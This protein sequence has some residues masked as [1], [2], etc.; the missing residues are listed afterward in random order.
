MTAGRLHRRVLGALVLALIAMAAVWSAVHP[1]SAVSQSDCA[2]L[3]Q[4]AGF[5]AFS[6]EDFNASPPGGENITGRIAAAHN[7]AIEGPGSAGVFVSPAPGDP[8]PTVIAGHDL[9]LGLSGA[10]GNLSG[11]ARYGNTITGAPNFIVSGGQQEASPGFSFD[12]EFTSLRSLSASLAD[13]D[14]TPGAT[15]SLNPGSHA[16][17]LRGTDTATN[18]FTVSAAQLTQAAGITI[19]LTKAG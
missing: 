12:D 4:A 2:S 11:G 8:S 15:V 1:A 6:H 13:E 3:G 18:V 19:T 9:S 14:Q 7:V 10:G 5:V 16:L 17:E